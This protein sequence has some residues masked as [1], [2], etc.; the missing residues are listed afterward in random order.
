MLHRHEPISSA[1]AT[2]LKLTD[3]ALKNA[4]QILLSGTSDADRGFPDFKRGREPSL[5]MQTRS[6]PSSVKISL[7]KGLDERTLKLLADD[8][9]AGAIYP[10][11]SALVAELITA[12]TPEECMLVYIKFKV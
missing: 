3:V 5:L 4:N 12:S 6:F 11:P 9:L 1:R 8:L 10:G 2:E 7:D